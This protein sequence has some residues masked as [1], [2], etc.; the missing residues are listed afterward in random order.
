M[1]G[2]GSVLT[3]FKDLQCTPQRILDKH[4]PLK[5]RYVKD[6][7]QNLMD[8]ELIQAIMVRSKL[9]KINI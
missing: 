1:N 9:K 4:T 3:K 8:K 2:S 6:N 5:K 7:Q